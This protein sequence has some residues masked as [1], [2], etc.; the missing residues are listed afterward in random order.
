MPPDL[1]SPS[2]LSNENRKYV[3][4]LDALT[5]WS[6]PCE[7]IVS[8]SCCA[9]AFCNCLKKA[10]P[11]DAPDVAD[12]YS[13]RVLVRSSVIIYASPLAVQDGIS[14]LGRMFEGLIPVPVRFRNRTTPD[15]SFPFSTHTAEVSPM[16]VGEN[17][18]SIFMEES[19]GMRVSSVIGKP[20]GLKTPVG[21]LFFSMESVESPL[22]VIMKDWVY[23]EPTRTLPNWSSMGKTVM[24][25]GIATEPVIMSGKFP[26]VLYSLKVGLNE[27][28]RLVL[29]RMTTAIR[30]R[31]GIVKFIGGKPITSKGS[32]GRSTPYTMQG[33]APLFMYS[34][35]NSTGGEFEM[36]PPMLSNRSAGLRSRWATSLKP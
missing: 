24:T 15:P 36:T 27:P 20:I 18:R 6:G 28:R 22:F 11:R 14:G 12:K 3:Y 35:V 10:V 26:P 5:D 16:D 21:G 2:Q 32:P 8:P 9:V 4:R 23:V 30:W 34:M 33:D 19:G 29:R 31:G 25:G 17:V 7:K 13:F 1:G